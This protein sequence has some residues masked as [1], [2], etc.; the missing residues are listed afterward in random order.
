MAQIDAGETEFM[1]RFLT[2]NAGIGKY[3]GG[4]MQFVPHADVTRSD[5]ALTCVEHMPRWQLLANIY[6]LYTG[7]LLSHSRTIGLHCT[8][9]RVA[10]DQIPIE[11]DG[12]FL[13]YTPAQIS[14]VPD[15]FRLVVP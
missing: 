5:F 1:G 2:I 8:S 4:G 9:L 6:R 13:G 10:G 7:T 15:A 3:S 12:E 14:F 11:A